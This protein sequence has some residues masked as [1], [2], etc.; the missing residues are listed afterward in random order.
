MDTQLTK[1]LQT[2][3]KRVNSL[4]G[5]CFI[6]H[7][8]EQDTYWYIV[9]QKDAGQ[10]ISIKTGFQGAGMWKKENADWL[11]NEHGLSDD[12]E[13]VSVLEIAGNIDGSIN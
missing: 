2:I 12:W 6:R 10:E 1:D 11:I 8:H 9:A 7:K 13:A 3:D 4:A 5:L